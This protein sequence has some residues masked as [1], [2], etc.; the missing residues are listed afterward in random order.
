MKRN[1]KPKS[2]NPNQP[3][4]KTP[5]QQPQ[6]RTALF[7]TPLRPNQPPPSF[8]RS[9]QQPT[10][11]PNRARAPRPAARPAPLQPNPVRPRSTQT[12]PAPFAQP[13]SSPP[14]PC[15]LPRGSPVPGLFPR[16]AQ[17]SLLPAAPFRSP[18]LL[19]RNGRADSLPG[20]PLSGTKRRNAHADASSRPTGQRL[21]PHAASASRPAS[22][23]SLPANN[24]TQL[25]SPSL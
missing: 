1:P 15:L 22:L 13:A 20:P 4:G 3:K 2:R 5:A 17:T 16:P 23:F 21:T 24:S 6:T 18:A 12:G 14:G 11:Q 10:L 9:A 7:L 8:S 25:A 19:Q